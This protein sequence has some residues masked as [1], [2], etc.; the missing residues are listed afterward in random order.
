[1]LM[2]E[3]SSASVT[4]TEIARTELTAD[5][6]ADVSAHNV[7]FQLVPTVEMPKPTGRDEADGTPVECAQL[8]EMAD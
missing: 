8:F 3:R 5:K 2:M 6:S 1:M 7:N 4:M